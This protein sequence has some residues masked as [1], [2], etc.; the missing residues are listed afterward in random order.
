MVLGQICFIGSVT[1]IQNTGVLTMLGF[2]SVILGYFVS[3]FKYKEQINIFCIIG[4]ILI[5]F[6]LGKILL[7]DNE[8]KSTEIK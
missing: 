3:V 4:A 6:G 5:L 1:M 7:K 8:Q 2:I